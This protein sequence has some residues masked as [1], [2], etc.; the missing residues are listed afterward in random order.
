LKE[1]PWGQRANKISRDGD[2][3]KTWK[4]CH[5]VDQQNAQQAKKPYQ[6]Y[7]ISLLPAPAGHTGLID[8]TG[9]R[10]DTISNHE[11]SLFRALATTEAASVSPTGMSR[12]GSH[13]YLHQV[14]K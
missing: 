9:G 7:C 2:D 11:T 3:E 4:L 6:P 14:S 5:R 13:R 12:T 8:A 10:L 1:N